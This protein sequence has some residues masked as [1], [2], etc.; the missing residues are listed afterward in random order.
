VRK[1]ADCAARGLTQAQTAR[2]LGVSR[3]SVSTAAKRYG[4]TFVRGLAGRPPADYVGC[5]A[6]GLTKKETATELGVTL[7][8][9]VAF[10]QRHDVIFARPAGVLRATL[11]AE[12]FEEYR[13]LVNRHRYRR[14]EALRAIGR[15]DLLAVP[16]AAE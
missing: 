5:A 10:S 7:S 11:P 8:A 2:E 14:S 6:R 3:A 15:A 4:Y 12:Q 9:V 1:Y 16:V 13:Y